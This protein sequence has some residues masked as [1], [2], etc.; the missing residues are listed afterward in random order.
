MER[1]DT[2]K[3]NDL[4]IVQDDKKFCFG[5]DALLLSDFARDSVKRNSL[6]LDLCTGN[7]ILP[8][9]FSH[10]NAKKIYGIEIQK[11]IFEM[12]EKS[13]SLNNLNEK[14]SLVHGDIKNITSFFSRNFFDIVTCNPPYMKKTTGKISY[15]E[16][17][18]IARTEIE[19]NLED[20]VKAVSFVMKDKGKFFMIHR[21]ERLAEIILMLDKYKMTVKKLKVVYPSVDKEACMILLE[22][23]KNACS[24]L[25]LLKP[26]IVYE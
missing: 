5:I 21:P 23:R 1:I 24:D 12:A 3:Y 8:L 17:K 10:T 13:I 9:M 11:P 20:V 18:A 2:L 7:G 15:N 6:V 4:K 16:E 22:A 26:E 14:I 25:K 19:C